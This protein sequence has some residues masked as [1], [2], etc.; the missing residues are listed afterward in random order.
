MQHP[1]SNAE[2]KKEND[3]GNNLCFDRFFLEEE[4]MGKESRLS[5]ADQEMLDSLGA[6]FQSGPIARSSKCGKRK[7]RP[8][9]QCPDTPP[10]ELLFEMERQ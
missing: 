8:V 9:A 10:P 3:Q 5:A 1:T 7:K 4:R 6:R 2:V